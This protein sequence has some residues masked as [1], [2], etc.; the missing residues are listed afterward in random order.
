MATVTNQGARQ[1]S[2]RGF[3][4]D[5]AY[6][7]LGL[8]AVAV[9]V[10]RSVDRVRVAAPRQACTIGRQVPE[11]LVGAADRGISTVRS[12]PEWATREFDSLSRR[13]RDLVGAIGGSAATGEAV[14]RARSA[15]SRVKAA[16]TSVSRAAEGAVQAAERAGSIVADRTE[17]SEHREVRV[18]PAEV[19]VKPARAQVRT[20]RAKAPGRRR[21]RMSPPY[22]ERTV[23]EL[24]ERAKELGIE[25]RASM[26]KDEL[27]TALRTQQTTSRHPAAP[28][29]AKPERATEPAGAKA[30][31]TGP[32]EERTVEELQER[33]K[34]LGI[35]GR[36]SM[37]KDEL[38]ASL[39]DQR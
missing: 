21:R 26:T 19:Q 12:L 14:D 17:P 29:Q 33:A 34:E 27:I 10:A 11:R 5:S 25:G 36:A 22:E 8:G 1:R 9:E 37:T 23:E 31:Q 30:P 6:A 32:Y 3:L 2:L 15:R 16:G 38:I 24:Q 28:A 4:A 13:G 35:E 39:R 20:K 18:E 7:T